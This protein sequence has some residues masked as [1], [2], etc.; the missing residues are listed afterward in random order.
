MNNIR[1]FLQIS[2]KCNVENV[3]L[4]KLGHPNTCYTDFKLCNTEF[5]FTLIISPHFQLFQLRFQLFR[6]ECIFQK[7][8]LK[9][10]EHEENSEIELDED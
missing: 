7:E 5:I 8:N 4:S 6:K 2:E 9:F 1:S 3:D 10:S